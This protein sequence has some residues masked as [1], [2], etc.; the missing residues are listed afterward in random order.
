MNNRAVGDLKRHH[1]QYDVTVMM[2][3]ITE[4]KAVQAYTEV[5]CSRTISHIPQSTI[6]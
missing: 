2:L 5:S 1:A 6:L 3:Q 4:G